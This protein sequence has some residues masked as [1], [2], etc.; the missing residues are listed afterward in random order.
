MLKSLKVS[1]N[2]VVENFNE[3][4]TTPDIMNHAEKLFSSFDNPTKEKIILNQNDCNLIG[5]CL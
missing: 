2:R 4:F 5:V 3:S 1:M